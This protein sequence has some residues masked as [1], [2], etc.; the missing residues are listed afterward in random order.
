MEMDLLLTVC[1]SVPHLAGA[2]GVPTW[3]MLCAD[4]YWV[5]T[6]NGDTTPWYPG[7][8]L[9]RQQRLG[10]WTSV[11]D[12]VRIALSTLADEKLG[13]EVLPFCDAWT[14]NPPPRISP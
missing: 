3:T 8:R 1:T 10:D 13:P 6:R 2:I 4:P 11:I 12:E 5:W 9:F 7:M 14:T